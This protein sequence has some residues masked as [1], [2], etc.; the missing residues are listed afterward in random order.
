[1]ELLSKST[2]YFLQGGWVMFPILACSVFMW[3]FIIE[4]MQV[5]RELKRDDTTI[6]EA[7][8]AIR[9]GVF[10]GEGNGFRARFLR[11][12][13]EER[14]GISNIDRRA[15]KHR[16]M[17][18]RSDL[19]KRLAVI[20]MLAAVTPLLG[21]L[22]TVIGMIET[23]NVIAV[24]GTGNAKAMANGISVALIT[25]ETGLLV[26]IPGLFLASTLRR[27][28]KQFKTQLEQDL[29]IFDRAIKNTYDVEV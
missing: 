13:M 21:L 24:F 10:A 9:R 6:A 5:M 22:G 7:V 8:A 1:M 2:Q 29:T 14:S 18:E 19:D 16:A 28:S 20:S 11:G 15:L 25:T 3:M 27:T 26:A 23:F 4:R 17:I 12:F